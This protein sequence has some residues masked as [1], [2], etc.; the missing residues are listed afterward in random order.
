[1]ELPNFQILIVDDNESNR[2]MLSR[3]LR[4]KDLS[5]SM[6]TNGRE[7]L[8]MIR[9]N[10]YDLILLD[11]MMPEIDGYALLKYLKQDS[12]LRNIPVIMISAIE[13]MDSVM[14]CMEIG[15]YDYLIK[16]FDPEMLKA[17]IN[18]CLPSQTNPRTIPT[19]AHSESPDL[20]KFSS[21]GT[22][23]KA[24]EQNNEFNLSEDIARGKSTNAI[25]LDEVVLRI[26]QSGIINR[27]GYLYFSKVI[28]NSL[29]ENAGLSDREITQIHSI[30]NDIY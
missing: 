16:P 7:S 10:H 15:A 28:Y 30:F 14:Q 6:A 12:S 26:T 13:E 4:R 29:F 3:R 11:I 21:V 9:A 22:N 27:K 5:L 2:D 17:A 8:S 18:R 23:T 20:S 24:K 25:T 1:M 19:S